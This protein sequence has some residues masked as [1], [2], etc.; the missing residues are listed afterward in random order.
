MAKSRNE[1]SAADRWNVEALY[2]DA[3][4]WNLAFNTLVKESKQSD[5]KWPKIAAFKGK[6]SDG[7]QV[8]KGALDTMFDLQ[9]E[10][11]KLYTYA[12]LR[13]DEEITND[14]N[15][16]NFQKSV[17]LFHDYS[18]NC[19]WFD[20]EVLALSDDKIQEYLNSPLVSPYKFHIEKMV[21]VKKHTLKETEEALLAMS[22]KALQ[23]SHQAFSAI[24]DADFKFGKV[25]DSQGNSFDL[26]H[27][28][29]GMHIRS[30]D[31]VLRENAFKG[32]LGKYQSFQN[33]LCELLNGTI[34]SHIFNAKARGYSS[35]LEA[36]LFPKNIDTSV[37]ASLITAVSEKLPTSLHRY[38]DL[39]EK[40]LGVGKLHLYDMYNPLIKAIDIKMSYEEAEEIVIES[41]LPLG[42]EYQDL[43]KQGFKEKRWVDRYENENKRS[44]A[45]SSG[46]YDSSPYILMNYKG[47]L[48]DVFTL[49]HEA[50]HSMHSLLT[51]THQPYQYGNYPIFL[52]EV[53]STFNEDLLM[54]LMLT[55]A[56]SKE[57]RIFL[58]NEKIEDIRGTLF[59]QTMF[60]EFEL[61][62]HEM[63]EKEVPL[64][65]K[66]LNDY[67]LTL[68]RKYF[69]PNVILTDEIAVEW[70]RIPHFYYNFY[71]YQYATGISAAIALSEKVTSGKGAEQ[72]DY[73]AFLKSGSSRYPIETLKK[74]G[75]N[76]QETAPVKAAIDKFSSMVDQL[77]KEI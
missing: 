29:Y 63:G 46:C 55:R 12:H 48:R 25:K 15:K 75:V 39:R 67:Y 2:K 51:H 17:A 13:H 31:R 58:L 73:L 52:A 57:E 71:V 6:L 53:A 20:P 60:A 65:P 44:G 77:A 21:R 49:A 68:N 56:K 41:V 62:L 9:R 27:G 22:A 16:T 50:G 74:A 1:V 43:L 42:K 33:T 61:F 34:Q 32:L 54:R 26:T 3:N 4:E 14:E 5:Q 37:Y 38:M 70:A 69:G 23:S 19:A 76:M 18:E 66:L 35:C 59:R 28:S 64:T 7:P 36:A 45:Y 30:H 8:L 11:T 40:V 47:I 10:L 72:Q 24:N